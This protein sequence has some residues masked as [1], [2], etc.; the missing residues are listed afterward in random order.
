M[1]DDS[2]M[3]EYN[4]FHVL[5][6]SAKEVLMCRF[7]ADILNPE[8]RHGYGSLFL[9][10]FLRDVLKRSDIN[11]TLLAHT[12]VT[13]EYV[14]DHDRRIDIVIQNARFQIPMEVKIYADEQEGQLSMLRVHL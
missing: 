4:L 13:K 5:E 7:L 3:S 12:D 14:I 6:I 2:F 9:K 8:G 1:P 10:S 11:D